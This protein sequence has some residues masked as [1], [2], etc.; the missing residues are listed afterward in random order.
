MGIPV[1]LRILAASPRSTSKMAMNMEVAIAHKLRAAAGDIA[2]VFSRPE[3]KAQFTGEDFQVDR[4]IPLS[5]TTAAVIYRKTK[6]K[7]AAAFFFYRRRS[8]RWEWFFPTDSHVL[9]MVKFADVLLAIER[10][11]FPL[12]FQ[13]DEPEK[14][15]EVS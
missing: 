6:G 9:G 3:R 2:R 15:G 4:I 5:E 7:V 14:Q 11:N 8:Q 1:R 13:K 10:H 12:N